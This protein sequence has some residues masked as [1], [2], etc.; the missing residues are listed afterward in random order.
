MITKFA[1]KSKSFFEKIFIF[2]I[3]V[4]IGHFSGY[5]GCKKRGS[6]AL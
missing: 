3:Y 2:Q 5:N 4:A 1:E 6:D